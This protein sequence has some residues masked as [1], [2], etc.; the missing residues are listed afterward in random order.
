MRS[1]KIRSREISVGERMTA[2]AL[3][4]NVHRMS[5]EMT[6]LLVEHE[7]VIRK[8]ADDVSDDS[9]R[10]VVATMLTFIDEEISDGEKSNGEES[11]SNQGSDEDPGDD[12]Q[13]V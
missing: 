8:C 7:D 5:M 9:Y 3:V 2:K 10:A 1:N 12:G 11:G 13:V 6:E 4:A